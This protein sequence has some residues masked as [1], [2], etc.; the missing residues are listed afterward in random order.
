MALEKGRVCVTGAGGYLASWVV[1]H[2]LSNGYFVHGTVE[3]LAPA[4]KGTLNVLKACYEAK[5]KQ[6]VCVS[7]DVAVCMNPKWPKGKVMDETCW[8]DKDYC[9]TTKVDMI[10]PAVVGTR[11]VLNACS[12]AKAKRVVV[13]SSIA[14]VINN[15]NWSKDHT[16]DE[17]CWSDRDF[18]KTTKNFYSLAKTI[19]ESEAFEYAKRGELD[20]V[21]VCP[22]IVIGTMLQPTINSS[23]LL[24]LTMLKGFFLPQHFVVR[25]RIFAYL[26]SYEV[27]KQSCTISAEN[28]SS[29]HTYFVA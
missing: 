10:E 23:S 2:L 27:F 4:V 3:V 17:E 25:T 28:L 11:N 20:I 6:V 26:N 9:R 16:M 21:T 22:S 13:V 24:L 15:P 18:C 8:S 14:A 7:S 1:K 29:S 12:K 5:V 19:A